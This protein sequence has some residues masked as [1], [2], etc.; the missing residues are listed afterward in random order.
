MTKVDIYSLLPS[1]NE[2]T[3]A[4]R[5]LFLHG[6][7]KAKT[8]TMRNQSSLIAKFNTRKNTNISFVSIV[9]DSQKRKPLLK[10]YENSLLGIIY[11][12]Y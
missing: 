4:E 10:H 12:N 6:N 3:M 1:A 9:Q 8:G 7:L 2:G 11:K 5:L